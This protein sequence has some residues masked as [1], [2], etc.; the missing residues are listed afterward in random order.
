MR[1]LLA[2]SLQEYIDLLGIEVD[3]PEP[4]LRL[5]PLFLVH[6]GAQSTSFGRSLLVGGAGPYEQYHR[7]YAIDIRR[8]TILI[9][10]P[11]SQ[12]S[13]RVA[14]LRGTVIPLEGGFQIQSDSQALLIK[15]TKTKGSLRIA[16]LFCDLAPL[17]GVSVLDSQRV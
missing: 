9:H 14:P 4:L 2:V 17:K 10:L 12:H 16:F 6:G 13:R 3:Q 1:R 5:F 11:E 8:L 15:V 7:L